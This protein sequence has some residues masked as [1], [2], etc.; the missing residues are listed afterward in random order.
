MGLV[1]LRLLLTV[2]F[3][4]AFGAVGLVLATDFRGVATWHARRS[5]GMFWQPTEE[6][7]SRQVVLEKVIGWAFTAFAMIGLVVVIAV[8]A[9]LLA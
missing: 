3:L 7:V 4:L 1:A 9:S 8:I 2:L 5:V 6:R